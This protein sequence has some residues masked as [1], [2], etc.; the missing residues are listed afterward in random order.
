[1]ALNKSGWH[2]ETVRVP[3][4]NRE[5][6]VWSFYGPPLLV[7][8]DEVRSAYVDNIIATVTEAGAVPLIN[9]P[10][11]WAV[12]AVGPQ[13]TDTRRRRR[14]ASLHLVNTTLANAKE[15]AEQLLRDLEW[16]LTTASDGPQA[17][18]TS[19]TAE[20]IPNEA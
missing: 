3:P 8:V 7:K 12:R 5:H 14:A 9:A 6:V 13:P 10:G 20:G 2:D 11:T 4:D 18:N 19:H 1:M 16:T 17:T 15:Q